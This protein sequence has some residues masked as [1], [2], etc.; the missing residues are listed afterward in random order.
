MKKF[1]MPRKKIG[2]FPTPITEL[3]QLS[4]KLGG[5][6]IFI[7]R[8]DLT[9]LAFGGNKTRKLEFLIGDA[10]SKGCDTI[11]TGGAEQSNHCRQTAAACAL[12]GLECH[13]VL[14]GSEPELPKGNFLLDKLF[15]ANIHWTGTFRKGEKIPQITEELIRLG[16]KP[17]II[18]YGG[19]NE[20]G[21]VGFVEAVNELKTQLKEMNEKIS[22]VV[23][24]SSSGGTHAGLVLG[25]YIYNQNYILIG[26]EIDKEE[27]GNLVYSDHLLN[28][29]NSSAKFLG[30][31]HTFTKNDLILKN[32][33]LGEGYGVVGELE[34]NAIKLLAET[35][36]ILVDPVYTGRTFGALVD[37]IKRGEFKNTDAVLFWHTGGSPSIFSYAEKILL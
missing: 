37:M 28:L 19:S 3:K 6:R 2:F 34:K 15:A 24:A 20:I 33:Y 1:D 26:V 12:S 22:H 31:D 8:D 32:E 4:K 11:I 14:G 29:T 30:I 35:E 10:L 21:V 23:F 36:G 27:F 18:P 17:Y 7:K 9:G 13:L 5:P 16:K 25:K